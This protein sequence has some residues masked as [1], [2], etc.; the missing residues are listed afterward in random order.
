MIKCIGIRRE[1]KNVWERRTPLTP[2]GIKM[3]KSKYGLEFI[4]E[5]SKIRIFPD[6]EYKK[7]GAKVQDD[8][9][10]CDIV[11]AIKEIPLG[12]FKSKKTY[13]FFAHVIKGQS[14]NMPMLKKML[15]QK[16]QLI[17]YE[18]VVDEK[19][20]RLIF[21]GRY[22]GLAGMLDTL[23]AFEQRLN[24]EGIRTPFY[25]IKQTYKYKDLEE[26]KSAIETVGKR[27]KTDG[28]PETL[29][30]LICGF[31]GYG[32]VSMG[33]QEI[34]D[35]LP[36]QN[37]APS[38]LES[39]IKN[40]KNSTNTLFKVVFKE[41]DIVEPISA[42]TKFELQ[43]YYK[44]PEKYRSIFHKYVPHLTILVNGIYWD[45]RYPRL[46]TKEY[47]KQLY[48]SKVKPSLR[49]IGDISCDVEGSIEFTMH[50][51][52]TDN[53]V[54]VYD[55][56]KNKVTDGFKGAGPVVMSIDNLP[57]ELPKD[58]SEFFSNTLASFIPDLAKADYSTEFDKLN[59]PSTLK[60]AVI[61][62]HGELTPN[63]KYICDFL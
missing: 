38:E 6:A 51:T 62:Y 19:G 11:F 32:N 14:H 26:V 4:V 60:N 1:D 50:A 46:I 17:D 42:G 54:F 61:A 15:K 13:M 18:K 59:L 3:L 23:W 24:W 47:L 30:P 7:A 53:P 39:V 8:I 29:T 55:P 48:D 57:C 49:V 33:A 63:Y 31:T 58:S 10:K 45:Q 34:F 56:L 41:E 22:A 40:N 25:D 44:H 2:A 20:R 9:S 36:H 35:I 16:C 21:F 27:I 43:D 37:V 52:T 5:P 28:L 12:F